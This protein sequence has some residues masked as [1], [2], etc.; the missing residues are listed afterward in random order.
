MIVCHELLRPNT[1]DIQGRVK[2]GDGHMKRYKTNS[3]AYTHIFEAQGR[4]IAQCL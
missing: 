4:H 3:T 2:H 1:Q